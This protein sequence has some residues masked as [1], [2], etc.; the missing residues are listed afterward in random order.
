MILKNA[1]DIE[2]MKVKYAEDIKAWEEDYTDWDIFKV[3]AYNVVDLNIKDPTSGSFDREDQ[4][5]PFNQN[6]ILADGSTMRGP[7]TVTEY[8][9]EIRIASNLFHATGQEKRWIKRT[10]EFLEQW[11]LSNGCWVCQFCLRINFQQT[12]KC[13]A[14]KCPGENHHV[15]GQR[16]HERNIKKIRFNLMRR[17]PIVSHF[18]RMVG[19]RC[20]DEVTRS[21]GDEGVALALTID[22]STILGAQS[23]PKNAL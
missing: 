16:Q 9:E 5:S 23:Y 17:L 20:D 11:Q 3:I 13:T 18:A 1:A 22:P 21:Y 4:T 2:K 14:T 6:A 7:L 10:A 12:R 19:L 8:D 15:V